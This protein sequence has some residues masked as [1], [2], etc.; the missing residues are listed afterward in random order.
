[1]MVVSSLC[2]IGAPNS[3][4]EPFGSSLFFLS[5]HPSTCFQ[6]LAL[7]FGEIR[8]TFYGSLWDV[9][10]LS[11]SKNIAYTNLDLGLHMDLLYFQSPPRFQFLHVLKSKVDGGESIFVDSFA[12]AE[13]M[14]RQERDLW[15]ILTQVKVGYWYRN[16]GKFYRFNHNVL[17]IDEDHEEM[18]SSG[19]TNGNASGIGIGIGEEKMEKMPRLKAVNYSPPFQSPLP[20]IASS[21][22]LTAEKRDL[23]FKA[24]QRF[25]EL[26]HEREF[27][28][29]RK[30]DEKECVI[31]DNRR[32]LHAR[33]GFEWHKEDENPN[34]DQ[35]Q[36]KG[37]RDGGNENGIHGRDGNEDGDGHAGK[38]KRWLKG[39]YVD[40]DA[41]WSSHRVLRQKLSRGESTK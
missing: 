37:I 39:C 12:I 10:S 11:E 16:D 23:F 14:W 2:S 7:Q 25:T 20:L 19:I 8:S 28:Y 4:S 22:Q 40:G 13:Q 35:D 1:M 26:S 41:I 33:R 34:Q 30:L 5:F 32:V 18:Q 38:V 17:E 15:T 24:F 36:R 27:R 6:S 21:K 9:R 31:F 3:I 29:E